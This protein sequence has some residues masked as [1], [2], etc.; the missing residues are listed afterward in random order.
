MTLE[1]VHA[2]LYRDFATIYFCPE[3][4]AEQW[5]IIPNP[6]FTGGYGMIGGQLV[7]TERY[8]FRTL[9]TGLTPHAA[10][11]DYLARKGES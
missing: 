5:F 7:E 10:Y 9:G 8:V 6:A 3:D 11:L 2:R 1:E 4:E